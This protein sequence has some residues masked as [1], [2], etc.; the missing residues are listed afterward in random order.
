MFKNFGFHSPIARRLIILSVLAST[1]IMIII[2]TIQLYNDYSDGINKIENEFNEI[3]SILL[4]SITRSVWIL[5]N[6]QIEAQLSGLLNF[7]GAEYVEIVVDGEVNWKKGQIKSKKIMSHSWDMS[8]SRN[9][10]TI[11]VGTLNVHISLDGLRK[12][13]F[14]SALYIV[15]ANSIKTCLVMI[16]MLFIIH[17]LVVR[18]LTTISQFF[19]NHNLNNTLKLNR[20]KSKKA[21]SDE[22]DELVDEVNMMIAER[23]RIEEELWRSEALY[24][25]TFEQAAVGIAHI[26]PDGTFLKINQ[27]Y[28]DIVGYSMDEM[29]TKTF[30]EITYPDDLELNL[31]YV[32]QVLAF[33]IE[34]YS[35]EKRYF[36]KDQSVVWVNLTVALQCDES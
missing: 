29:L 17:Y 8:V 6:S 1:L 24:R 3:D 4:N 2:S 26:S 20:E 10:E 30:Q 5:D 21:N 7:E 27:R 25:D 34:S 23:K 12:E 31:E 32:R 16:F 33:E 9:D 18:H 35:M 15:I 36:R 22:L 19:R 13:I 28:C 14:S 11:E